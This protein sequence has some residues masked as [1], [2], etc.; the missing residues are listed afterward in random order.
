ML[1]VP[2]M[3]T[4]LYWGLYWGPL[5]LRNCQIDNQRFSVE[6][7]L[8]D[9]GLNPFFYYIPIFDYVK[10]LNSNPEN[11]EQEADCSWFRSL[12]SFLRSVF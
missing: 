2:I 5:I 11:H 12:G 4:I 9:G 7:S 3:R 6:R 10:F 8:A 1:R